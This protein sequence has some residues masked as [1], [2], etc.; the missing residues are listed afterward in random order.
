ML[1]AADGERRARVKIKVAHC[2]SL[3]PF[4]VG[5]LAL[6]AYI[7]EPGALQP[8]DP[9]SMLTPA[10]GLSFFSLTVAILS[11]APDEGWRE[12]IAGLPIVR[13]RWSGFWRRR[14]WRLWHGDAITYGAK[15]N[16]YPSA[17]V[18]A[19]IAFCCAIAT[20]GLSLMAVDYTDMQRRG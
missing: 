20:A 4:A 16:L 2:L 14:L 3:A 18:P 6:V 19:L 15:L 7:C 12:P 11:V 5:Y 1:A 8:V 10:T 9:F 17:Y 13:R